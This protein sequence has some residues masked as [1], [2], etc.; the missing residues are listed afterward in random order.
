VA[1]KDFSA[2]THVHTRMHTHVDNVYINENTSRDAFLVDS[3][4]QTFARVV[5]AW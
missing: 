1:N 4:F 3:A 5:T 2:I